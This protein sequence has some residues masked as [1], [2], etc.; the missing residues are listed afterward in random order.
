[1]RAETLRTRLIP[2]FTHIATATDFGYLMHDAIRVDLTATAAVYCAL[3]A[4]W[5][6]QVNREADFLIS[7][8]PDLVFSDVAYLPLA[9]AAQAGIPALAMSSLNWAE[10]FHHYFA[11]APWAGPIHRQILAAYNS[12]ECFLRLTPGM[13][14]ADLQRVC[15][16]GP[17]AALG[18]D[19]RAALCEQLGCAAHE[20]LVLIAFG[21]FSKRLP[22]ESWPHIEGVHWL[23]HE[24]WQLA[25]ANATSFE[26]LGRPFVDLL[27]SVDA[28]ITKPGYGLFSEAGCN[29][30][31]VVYLRRND[32]PEQDCLI[33]WLEEYGR[34]REI[35]DADLLAG[36][37]AMPL[38]ELW[39]Q[40][41]RP[42]PDPTG[43][44]EAAVLILSRLTADNRN[45]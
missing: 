1:L 24:N 22:I 19:C 40:P 17:V 13:P 29:G 45:V 9:G 3:H 18:R 21:G 4:D 39:R 27:H 41:M 37:L 33:E 38:G 43:A 8:Q 34:C 10:L 6:T 31:P 36:R 7:L 2:D 25:H 14:M 12:A 30:T 5:T 28:V 11:D 35:S 42:M 20:R 44:D 23:V 16:V 32:W 15:P 26:S